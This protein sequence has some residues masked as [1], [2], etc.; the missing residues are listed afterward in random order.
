MPDTWTP[1]DSTT[2]NLATTDRGDPILVTSGGGAITR[3]LLCGVFIRTANADAQ[4]DTLP[5]KVFSGAPG[6][7]NILYSATYNLATANNNTNVDDSD[8]LDSPVPFYAQPQIQIGP[9]QADVT[10]TDYTVTL[11]IKPIA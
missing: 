9:V 8:M 1:I 2:Q 7:G 3:G 10:T 6:T 5:I 4:C 11:Y